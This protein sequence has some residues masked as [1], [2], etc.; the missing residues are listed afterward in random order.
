M[1]PSNGLLFRL[2]VPQP[3]ECRLPAGEGVGAERECVSDQGTVHQRILVWAPPTRLSFRME[4]TDLGSARGIEEIED[5]FD[6]MPAPAGVVVTR[7]TRAQVARSFS[8]LQRIELRV[9]LKQVHRH[10]FQN[11]LRI[12]REGSPTPPRDAGPTESRPSL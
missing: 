5:T 9:G 2:G 12:A 1:A 4:T 10:V 6:L 8:L 3:I 7:T 11:W